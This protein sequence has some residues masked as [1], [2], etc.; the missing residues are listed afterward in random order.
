[1]AATGQL[2]SADSNEE[3][4]E[5]TPNPSSKAFRWMMVVCSFSVFVTGSITQASFGIFITEIENVFS[6]NQA[7][8][9]LIGAL[10]LGLWSGG[11]KPL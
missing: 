7:M 6:L 8:I 5:S 11:G 3:H 4:T 9:G 1:M 2:D 10:R